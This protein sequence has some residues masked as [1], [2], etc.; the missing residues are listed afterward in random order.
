MK[1]TIKSTNEISSLFDGARRY[2]AKTFIA[3]I[4]EHNDRRGLNGR[5]A[6]IAGKRLG[7]A[8]LRSRAKRRLRAAVAAAGGG[9]GGHDLV[10]IASKAT[11][12]ADFQEIVSD[13]KRLCKR[14]ESNIS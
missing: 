13:I 1:N 11:L 10:F 9:G 14:F 3:L 4:G 12:L 8:P 7:S 6:Y 5:V 2:K